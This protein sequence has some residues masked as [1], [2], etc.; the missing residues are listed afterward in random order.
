MT[1]KKID[2]LIPDKYKPPKKDVEVAWILASFYKTVVEILRPVNRYKINTPDYH[3]NGAEYEMK[4]LISS[5]V[6]QLLVLLDDAK[7]Q[8]DNIVIDI[9]KTKI[10]EK[11]ASEVCLEFMRTHKKHKVFLV[12]SAKKVVDLSKKV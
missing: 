5:Q 11:R 4:A 12:V 9:R 8:A 2:V 10:T 1:K 7:E 6:R 3:F